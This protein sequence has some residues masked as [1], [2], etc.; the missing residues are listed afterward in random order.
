MADKIA[1]VPTHDEASRQNFVGSLKGFVNFAVES[2]LQSVFDAKLVPS[3]NSEFGRDPT[4]RDEAQSLLEAHPLYQFWATMTFH[5]QNLLWETVGCTTARTLAEQTE[6]VNRLINN[7]EKLGTVHLQDENIAPAPVRTVEIHRQPGGYLR[8]AFPGD[9]SAALTYMGSVELYRNAKGMGTGAKA[10]ADDFGRF[11]ASVAQRRAPDLV[12][13]AILD[14]GCGTGEQT[15]AYKRRHPDAEVTGIDCAR[16]FVRFAHALAEGEG[17]AMHFAHMDANQ[18]SF[19]DESFDLIVSIILFHETSNAQV[20]KILQESWR[21]LRPGGLVLHLDVPYQPHR[22]PLVKQVT[23]HWQV[24][25]NGEPFWTGFVELDM[26]EQLL[27]AGFQPDTAF[28]DYENLGEG[29]YL[30]FGGRKAK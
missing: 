14:M 2:R 21:L 18:T 30:V 23:N 27:Q 9:V 17:L 25:N 19:E 6:R 10:G 24:R 4:T 11:L 7:P 13:Q 20:Q 29:A 12:P 3:F 26:M 15:L 8:E 28:C 1:L 16:P 5:S 22:M